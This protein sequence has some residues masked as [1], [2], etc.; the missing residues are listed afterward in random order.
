MTVLKWNYRVDYL[1][2]KILTIA[3]VLLIINFAQASALLGTSTSS[4]NIQVG[5]TSTAPTTTTVSAP[6]TTTV[7]APTTTT[8]SAPTTTTVSAPVLSPDQSEVIS[9]PLQPIVNTTSD[10][11]SALTNTTS[12]TVSALTN[13]TSD[14]VSALTNTT[15][16][17]VSALTNTITQTL[18]TQEIVNLNDSQLLPAFVT[19]P[20]LNS[21]TLDLWTQSFSAKILNGTISTVIDN[22]TDLPQEIVVG[23]QNISGINEAQNFQ[24]SISLDTSFPSLTNGTT[25]VNTINM[26]NY[27]L[28]NSTSVVSIIPTIVTPPNETSGQFIATPSFNIVP[29]QEMIIPVADSAIPSFGGL[30]ELDVQ[31]SP[32]AIPTGGNATDEWF[33]AE[34]DN[35]LP[36]TISGAGIDGTIVLFINIQYPYD[37]TGVGFNWGIPAN[38]A[39]PPTMT[40]VINKTDQLGIQNDSNGCPVIDAYTLSLGSWTSNGLGEVSS[41]S[42]SPTQCQIKTQS[43]HLSKFAFSMRHIGNVKPSGPGQFGV[44]EVS[45]SA[46]PINWQGYMD[47]VTA[48]NSE[49]NTSPQNA[50]ALSSDSNIATSPGFS[51]IECSKGPGYTLMTGTYTN[52]GKSDEID[53]L[54]MSLLD[55]EGHV[56]ATGNGMISHA[57]VHEP[58]FFSAITRTDKDFASCTVQI[59]NSISK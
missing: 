3:T 55:K 46:S 54:Q 43:Q 58:T 48:S 36:S 19:T 11:V 34:V 49:E 7:S 52:N 47:K 5:V 1:L 42:I 31:S 16:D 27:T 24:S 20:L 12:D 35:K 40:L 18:S 39:K 29:G 21:T 28:P 9:V 53:F 15:S 37:D 6:T 4:S 45:D 2:K 38:H 44:G 13:T 14:T 41:S 50:Y 8:V 25:V 30:K 56:I 33:T 23:S 26:T 22:A 59:D 57:N 32:N 51:N 10:T 17:T